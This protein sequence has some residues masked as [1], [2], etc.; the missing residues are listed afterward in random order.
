MIPRYF[1]FLESQRIDSRLF[2]LKFIH[3]A[4]VSLAFLKLQCSHAHGVALPAL[5]H[6]TATPPPHVHAPQQ[7]FGETGPGPKNLPTKQAVQVATN[8]ML[9]MM[10][11]SVNDSLAEAAE[12]AAAP[13]TRRLQESTAP[14]S[15]EDMP[16]YSQFKVITVINL[17]DYV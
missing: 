9:G 7:H 2:A 13:P 8:T 4:L 12:A 3:F 16:E 11:S 14:T 5:P 17:D 1:S 10:V 15:V 6:P